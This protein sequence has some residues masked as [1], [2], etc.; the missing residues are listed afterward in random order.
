MVKIEDI[1]KLP[2]YMKA[3]ILGLIVVILVG[4]FFITSYIPKKNQIQSLEGEISKIEN[5]INVNKTKARR[6]DELKKENAELDRQLALKKQ[7][8]PSE[9]EVESL[10]K[11]VSDLGLRVGL[12]FKL[13]RPS[14][15][16]V[17]ESQL[18]LEIP[19]NVEISGDFHLVASFFDRVGKLQRIVNIENIR[20]ANPR[21]EKDRILL[22]TSFVATAFASYD[23]PKEPPAEKKGQDRKRGRR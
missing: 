19:V 17:N 2:G 15:K 23:A 5:E 20:M 3:T 10:L 22:N 8:L 1:N 16:R 21:L 12:D 7:Q 4:A 13:W 11:Q 6:L 18:Y 9:A 14:G